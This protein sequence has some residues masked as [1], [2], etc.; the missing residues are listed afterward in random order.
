MAR[1]QTSALISDIRGAVGG[2]VFQRSAQ[3]LTVRSR[4]TPIQTAKP[5]QQANR[6]LMAGLQ[7][8][9]QS[10]TDQQRT[11][12]TTWGQ[13]QNIQ[14]RGFVTAQLSGQ[15]VYIQV[16]FYRLQS[17]LAQLDDP[18][19]TPYSLLPT[20]IAFGNAGSDLTAV[21]SEDPGDPDYQLII[22]LSFIVR[23]GRNAQPSGLKFLLPQE[24][25]DETTWNYT[26][27]YLAAFGKLPVPGQ[28]LFCS[29]FLMQKSNGALGPETR[30]MYP[31]A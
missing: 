13:Y 2:N 5:T 10:L 28:R 27:P 30:Q 1:I 8:S 9:W 14:P 21:L 17:N 16:N 12:W 20:D 18:I 23:A 3:G 7:T 15:Q 6:S 19:F 24:Q 29:W 25:I 22:K 11:A 26:E 4:I 31:V